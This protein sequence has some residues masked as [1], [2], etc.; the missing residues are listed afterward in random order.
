MW[1]LDRFN[2]SDGKKKEFGVFNYGRHFL[3]KFSI[4]AE[5]EKEIL[6]WNLPALGSNKPSSDTRGTKVICP[7]NPYRK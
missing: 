1:I 5:T 2:Q 6:L 7:T 3:L 4:L